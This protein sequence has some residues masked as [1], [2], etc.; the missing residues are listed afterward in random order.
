[1]IP[2]R[3]MLIRSTRRYG[4]V[5]RQ[6]IGYAQRLDPRVFIPTIVTFDDDLPYAGQFMQAAGECGIA[7]ATIRSIHGAGTSGAAHL[8]E[9][10]RT[11]QIDMLC[12][13]DYRS[14]IYALMAGRSLNL[15]VV[16]TVHSQLSHSPRMRLYGLLNHFTLRGMD[17]IICASRKVHNCL[18]KLGVH[19]SKL[20]I[21]PSS[22]DPGLIRCVL[23]VD[24]Y[25][26]PGPAVCS[27]GRL[28]PEKGHKYLVD[29]WPKVLK[30]VP[31][32]RLVLAGDG[33]ERHRLERLVSYLGVGRSVKFAGF[34]PVPGDIMQSSD[35]FVLPSMKDSLPLAL[36]EA[37]AAGKPVVASE[38][39]AV[40]E[41]VVQGQ[42]G[43]LVRPGRSDELAD[44]II[45]FL[46]RPDTASTMGD[47]ARRV[48]SREFSYDTNIPLLQEAYITCLTGT[49]ALEDPRSRMDR[50]T[51]V[52][53]FHS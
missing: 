22:V 21:I 45:W 14:N 44:A 18:S 33:P 48:I 38:V 25:N 4:G 40:D 37:C 34:S 52:A 7:T 2:T 46:T 36:L 50:G 53:A 49:N 16:A 41:V 8:A 11:M 24:R 19:Q 15:P 26:T 1:M 3:I 29:A 51:R 30:R 13:Q 12:P 5:E 28:S 10:A 31:S 42:T 32:A 35:L 39:G 20:F 27:V 17:G 9:L 47:L 23:P 6:I 43:T